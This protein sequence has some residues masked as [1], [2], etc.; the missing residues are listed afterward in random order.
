MDTPLVS[1]TDVLDA[2][3]NPRQFQT[4]E[5]KYLDSDGDWILLGMSMDITEMEKFKKE[6]A[7]V[8]EERKAYLRLSA[9][10]GNLIELYYIDPETEAYTEFTSPQ[11]YEHLGR[12]RQGTD[13]FRIIL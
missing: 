4:T 11:G 8:E 2:Q 1:Y 9:L 3:G 12:A 7:R 10:S 5:V 13:F 6:S